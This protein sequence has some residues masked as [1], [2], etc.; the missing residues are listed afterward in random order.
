MLKTFPASP[1]VRKCQ[2]W[3]IEPQTVATNEYVRLEHHVNDPA[4]LS[5]QFAHNLW[6]QRSALVMPAIVTVSVYGL[7]VNGFLALAKL[8]ALSM[9]HV[10]R[11]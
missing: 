3:F 6:F 1:L 7:A 2:C 5:V 8:L 11:L 9:A 4:V 10:W